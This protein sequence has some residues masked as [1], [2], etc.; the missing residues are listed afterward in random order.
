MIYPASRGIETQADRAYS[1]LLNRLVF[2]DYAPGE[3]LSEV[4]MCEELE[5]GRTPVRE[6][7]KRLEG[8]GLVAFYPRRGTFATHVDITELTALYEYRA[9]LEPIAARFAA[10]KMDA[11]TRSEFEDI[12][13]ALEH[14]EG[15]SN[16]ELLELDT[17][18]H[19]AIFHGSGNR[20]LESDLVRI[21]NL[22]TRIWCVVLKRM[23][24]IDH[25]VVEHRE[26]INALLGGDGERAAALVL[27]HVHAFETAVRRVL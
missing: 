9:E 21:N 22:A 20:Y 10:T 7:L 14:V 17:R 8:D 23:P 18:V 2:L 1:I 27:E 15:K 11:G 12:L 5:I 24:D 4:H 3:L 19:L 13:R 26:I 6:A 16:R 25:H